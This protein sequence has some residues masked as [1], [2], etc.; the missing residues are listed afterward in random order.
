MGKRASSTPLDQPAD[1]TVS[2][3]AAHGAE[4]AKK[5]D[6]NT[7]DEVGPFEDAWDDEMEE[8]E[9]IEEEDA[10]VDG[11]M[12]V[13][14]EEDDDEEEKNDGLEAYLPG[15]ALE[16]GEELQV[17]LSAYHMLHSFNTPWPCLSF[18]IVFDGLGN[19][20]TN[21]PATVYM[22]AGTQ[23][24]TTK[25]NELLLLKISQLGR[26]M[27]KDDSDDSD[28]SDDETEDDPILES[29]HIPHFGGVN[30]LRISPPSAPGDL[31]LTAATFADTGKVHIFDLS[32]H[33]ASVDT[34]G[35]VVPKSAN[36][37]T[38]TV[39]AHNNEGYALDWSGHGGR[40]STGR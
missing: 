29:R 37:P 27:V 17:D 2:K 7:I 39:N 23:A 20:R 21:Y 14:E 38:Y 1:Q 13:D 3:V 19:N 33:I 4:F 5:G 30:R 11:E 40:T 12:A 6:V 36:Q 26:T 35:L 25:Q 8:E 32:S 22:V 9:V 18:D 31:S 10:D 28:G 34:T 16:E 15:Q 24:A